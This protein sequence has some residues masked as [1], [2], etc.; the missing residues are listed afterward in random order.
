M[1]TS[2]E[3][4]TLAALIARAWTDIQSSVTGLAPWLRR[5]VEYGLARAVGGLAHGLHG[6][7]AW[8]VEQFFPDLAS[9]EY[10][11]R[12][13]QLIGIPQLEGTRSSGDVVVTG[14]GGTITQGTQFVR[15]ADG[16]LYEATAT[17]AGL[18]DGDSI[19]IRSLTVGVDGD[20]DDGEELSFV[21]PVSGF[22][23]T[24]T[25]DTG[26]LTGGEDA[27]E[28]EAHVERILD[29][30][31]TPPM[32]GGPGDHVVWAEEVAGVTR[33]W[34]YAGKDGVGNPGLGKVAVAFVRDGDVDFI[35][36]A[37][38]VTTVQEYLDDRSPAEVIVFAPTAVEL[39]ITITELTP[40]TS[41]VRDAIEAEIEDMLAR[42]AEPGGTIKLSRIREAI[43][44]ATG[45]EDFTMTVPAADVEHEFGEIAK[46]GTITW[47]S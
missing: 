42:D 4:P 12:Y 10:R 19:T 46:L 43:S 40:D 27:E 35:P 3:R 45:E 47:P 11:K 15:L 9:D 8:G 37:G 23:S 17:N 33:A 29:R 7:I 44:T 24:V 22:D 36:S 30:L 2:F 31:Q 26:G 39:D 20:L 41:A 14:A 21:S 32:G 34:E 1:P 5:T 16:W 6:H 18:N 38:E 13:G 25:V 28:R